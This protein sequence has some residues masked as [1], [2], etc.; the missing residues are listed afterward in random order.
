MDNGVHF[1]TGS[2]C[3]K[4]VTKFVTVLGNAAFFIFHITFIFVTSRRTY[5][6]VTYT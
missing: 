6:L 4:D 2:W 3:Y 1:S 5:R